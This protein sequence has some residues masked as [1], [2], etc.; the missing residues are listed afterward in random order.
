[1]TTALERLSSGY[2]NS[3]PFAAG[4]NPG[5][6][7]AGGHVLNLPALLAD[8]ADVVATLPAAAAAEIDAA[9]DDRVEELG[10]VIGSAMWDDDAAFLAGTAEGDKGWVVSGDSELLA[11]YKR[12]DAG[13]VA[14][15]LKTA[16][17]YLAI[18]NALAA[19]AAL[20]DML[21]AVFL[22]PDTGLSF[23]I[24]DA[25]TEQA[26]IRITTEGQ[27]Q[28]DDLLLA[29]GV[30]LLENLA[31]ALQALLPVT[32]D[33][34]TGYSYAI[35][36]AV[37]ERAAIKIKVGGTV[38][39]DDLEAP[40]LPI[41][42]SNLDAEL[43]RR[44]L[45][46]ATDVVAVSPDDW[47]Y[48]LAGIPVRTADEGSL[49]SPLPNVLTP[50]VQ[51]LNGC[52]TALQFRKT[53][54]L[55][56]RGRRYAGAFD[57]GGQ[58]HLVFRGTFTT[59]APSTVGAVAGDYW[60]CI[61]LTP[62][63]VGADT[64]VVGDVAVW[65]GAALIKKAGPTSLGGA[66]YGLQGLHLP[67][68]WWIVSVAG[69][70]DGVTYAVGDRIV[71]VALQSASGNGYAR[72]MKGDHAG[73][74]ELFYRGEFAAG[75]GAMP[76]TPVDGEVWQASTAGVAGG[77]AWAIG[78]Y[79]VRLGGVWG[80]VP[81]DPVRDVAAGGFVHLPCSRTAAEW[82]TR[83]QDKSAARAQCQLTARRQSAP[84]RASDEMVLWSDSM[85]GVSSV[86]EAI[87]AGAG[88]TGT[89]N[90][91][92]GARSDEVV[93]MVEY[94]IAR[95]GDRYRGRLHGFWHG[96]NN[97][98]VAVGDENWVEITSSACRMAALAGA[99]DCRF[100]FM[101]ILGQ[102]LMA[103]NGAR[104]VN[105]QLEDPFAGTG[106]LWALEQ[107][108]QAG[109]SGQWT[110]P[111]QALLAAA[112]ASALPD[113]QYPGMT[114]AEV[115]ETYG[116]VPLRFYV[117]WS[118]LPADVQ[119]APGDQV[120]TGAWST[121]GLPA[122]GADGDYMIRTAAG[123]VGNLICRTAGVWTEPVL[124]VTHLSPHGAAALETGIGGDFVA[125]LNL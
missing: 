42:V 75:G 92:G 4:T 13:P 114:E 37:T 61:A 118:S 96:Q 30:I 10:A 47:R 43:R 115:A 1:M 73:R 51:G 22:D 107:W 62:Q 60:L 40:N 84:R 100:F 65:N 39:I 41:G 11:A 58:A 98:P 20:T 15:P 64:Y 93:N 90:S 94:E 33:P 125:A 71:Y 105:A 7:A 23:A 117:G 66:M 17:S 38:Q 116:V 6:L 106:A 2:Y 31:P 102:H 36:D 12:H 29:A 48:T 3:Q 9:A 63:V 35:D 86:G 119:S 21:G 123:T 113:L 67:G 111:R 32:L 104:L 97:Q 121:G 80:Q 49:W 110:S 50:A 14:T 112:A 124:D 82:E 88:R 16:P 103:W 8:V 19:L 120:Y 24:G 26:A 59:A 25:V 76:A 52:G 34:E 109:F 87:I 99:R 56:F 69:T 83:R 91:Y 72:W 81:T 70:F 122:G 53:S 27:V 78:D 95:L 89:V 108:Y 5:G 57:A 85:F 28:I 77:V 101:S 44:V 45:P 55:L 18:T 74:G 54:G 46:Q 68:D 79:A